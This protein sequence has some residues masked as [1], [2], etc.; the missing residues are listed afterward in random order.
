[1]EDAKAIL[2]AL[3]YASPSNTKEMVKVLFDDTDELVSSR[4]VGTILAD[5]ETMG[6]VSGRKSG[7]GRFDPKDW[8]IT[9]EGQAWLKRHSDQGQTEL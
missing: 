3:A 8:R 7:S 1:M 5:L 4:A 6:L 2:E 9:D